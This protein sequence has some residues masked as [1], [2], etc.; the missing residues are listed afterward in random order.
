M[1]VIMSTA[2][3]YRG[4]NTVNNE[5]I[6]GEYRELYRNGDIRLKSIEWDI[7][8]WSKQS[9]EFLRYLMSVI[10]NY[11]DKVVAIQI[12]NIN[13]KQKATVEIQK[14]LNLLKTEVD[15][16]DIM[17]DERNEVIF[18]YRIRKDEK[19]QTKIMFITSEMVK[20]SVDFSD[21]N[22]FSKLHGIENSINTDNLNVFTIENKEIANIE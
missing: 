13:L 12:Y 16:I 18:S 9:M 14:A 11:Q 1:K 19:I 10:R 17:I 5:Y 6:T 2:N 3:C 21:I 7:T 15:D 8:K 22:W 4:Y 20:N